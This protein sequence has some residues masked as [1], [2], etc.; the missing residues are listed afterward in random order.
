MNL[1][2]KNILV[3]GGAGFI[4]S[5]TVDLLIKEKPK[6]IIIYDNFSRGSLE[7]LRSSLKS[8]LVEIFK[9][10]G[11]ICHYEILNKAMQGIDIVF[12]FSALWLLHCAEY[13]NSAFK[14]NIEGTYNVFKA[15]V[16]NKVKK[17]I[18]SSSASVY[19][20]A[21]TK[22]MEES[23]PFNNKNFYGATKIAGEAILESFHHTYGLNYV[24]LRYMNVYGERQDYKGA[25]IAVIMK[26]I[27]N[28][29]NNKSP[30]LFG[31]G[32]EAFDFINV[33]DCARANISAAKSNRKRGFFNVCT[34]I[35][36]D[37]YSLTLMILNLMKSN[38]P[39]KF[40][41]IDNKNLVKNRIG[42]PKKAYSEINFKF[43]INL[44]KGLKKLIKWKLNQ[45]NHI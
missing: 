16:D 14:V 3:I 2:N 22:Y 4:G 23:H 20:D 24:G 42:S 44:E 39:I 7:N 11:D 30:V 10:G 15:C 34:G 17:I 38:L 1:I 25:Y 8:P 37:L 45:K 19:G 27:D 31:D 12:H 33:I 40:K 9:D 35:Q 36:T 28:I 29:Q 32:K 43:S 5:H 26:I 18:F 13:P 21:V 6:K 41:S